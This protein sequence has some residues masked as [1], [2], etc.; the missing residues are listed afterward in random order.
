[1]RLKFKDSYGLDMYV[2]D[3]IDGDIFSLHGGKTRKMKQ[4]Y[5][6]RGLKYWRLT[7]TTGPLTT[8][9]ITVRGI[10]LAGML[11]PIAMTINTNQTTE[12]ET[13]M[14][15]TTPTTRG[16]MVATVRTNGS[17]G[18]A[19]EPAMHRT[20]AE[21]ETEAA[22]LAKNNLG[23]RFAVVATVS[24]VVSGELVWSR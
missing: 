19:H 2:F 23:V 17:Y 24:S 13:K 21:A 22:R 9:V 1:M 5:D 14:N 18:F 3:T 11:T 20:L 10:D 16:F 12:K 4:Y 15:Q 6:K 7:R 8:T